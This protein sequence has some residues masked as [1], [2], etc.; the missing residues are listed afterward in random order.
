MNVHSYLYSVYSEPLVLGNQYDFRTT[1]ADTIVT[2]LGGVISVPSAAIDMKRRQGEDQILSYNRGEWQGYVEEALQDP[3][4]VNI[5]I[6]TKFDPSDRHLK[7]VAKFQFVED[8]NQPVYYGIALV[9]SNIIDLQMV[10]TAVD[11]TY[12]H[13][14]I[15]RDMLGKSMGNHLSDNPKDRDV[16]IRV[17][18]LEVPAE[19]KPENMEVIACAHLQNSSWDVLQAKQSKIED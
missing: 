4:P 13:Q 15:L 9:E 1:D 12:S 8:V 6:A 11:S 7:V 19:W 5:D 17:Y 3:V 2:M 18:D 16:F 14:H 10:G